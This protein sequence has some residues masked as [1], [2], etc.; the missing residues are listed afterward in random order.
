MSIM[1]PCDKV[2]LRCPNRKCKVLVYGTAAEVQQFLAS[3]QDCPK[4]HGS[5]VGA[6]LESIIMEGSTHA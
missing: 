6:K 4:C 5:M 1:Q 2:G 3:G